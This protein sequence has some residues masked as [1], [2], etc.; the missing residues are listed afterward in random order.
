MLKA[1][2]DALCDGPVKV[3][4]YFY[5]EDPAILD[6]EDNVIAVP[7]STAEL[8][9]ADGLDYIELCAVPVTVG[10]GSSNGRSTGREPRVS[11]RVGLGRFDVDKRCCVVL[12][13]MHRGIW[14]TVLRRSSTSSG[15]G[16]GTGQAF[17]FPL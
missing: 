9:L 6:L 16:P 2:K 13:R 3:H 14:R 11:P 12:D 8:L 10:G 1:L 7:P 4:G 17:S 15:G 5:Y